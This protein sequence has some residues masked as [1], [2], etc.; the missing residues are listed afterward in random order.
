[1]QKVHQKRETMKMYY[2]ALKVHKAAEHMT[3]FKCLNI[4]KKKRSHEVI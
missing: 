2:H 4:L 3:D 1:M